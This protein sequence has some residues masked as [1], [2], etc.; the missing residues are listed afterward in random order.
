[1]VGLAL[2]LTLIIAI[3]I[4]IYAGAH[5]G[6]VFDNVSS[7]IGFAF[8]GMPVFWLS[9]VLIDLFAVQMR[10]FPSSGLSS[11]GRENDVFDRLWHLVLPV[12]AIALVSFVSWMRYQRSSIIEAMSSAY[13]RTARSKGLSEWD[14]LVRHALRNALLP[15]ITLLGLSLP[16]LVGGAYFVEYVF[17]IP[18]VG[19]LTFTSIFTRDYPTLMAITMLT[20]VLIVLGNLLADVAYAFVDPRIRYG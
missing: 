10:W 12:V 1:M 5:R 8:Y 18:G 13:I 16:T 19:Y 4:G 20:A 2:L 14:V 3:P 6:S 7:A 9:I 15:I 17:S 11:L